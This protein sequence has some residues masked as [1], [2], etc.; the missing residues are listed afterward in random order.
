MLVSE[1]VV[2]SLFSGMVFVSLFCFLLLDLMLEIRRGRR[3][4]LGATTRHEVHLLFRDL[5][6]ENNQASDHQDPT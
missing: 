3:P 1:L 5:G 2:T 4:L 6:D